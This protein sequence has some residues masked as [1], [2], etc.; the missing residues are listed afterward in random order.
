MLHAFTQRSLLLVLVAAWL[1]A[2][3]CSWLDT[4][5]PWMVGP[6]FVTAVLRMG[7]LPLSCPVQLREAGQW[8]I[9]AA[10]GL[11]FTPPVVAALGTYVGYIGAGV[12]YAIVLGAVCGWVLHRMT[13][14]DRTT[15]FFAMAV[16]GASEMAAQGERHG[17]RVDRVAAAHSLRILLVVALIPFGFKF[18]AVHGADPFE[19][20]VQAVYYPGLAL[21]IVLTSAGSLLLKRLDTPNAW[22][23]GPLL[24]SGALTATHHELSA[25]PGWIVHW[26]Q[27]F[28]GVSLGARFSPE[29]LRTAP[30]FLG[31]VVVCTLLAIGLGIGFALALAATGGMH[32]ATAILATAPGGVAEMSLTARNLNLGVPIVTAFHVTRMAALVLTIEPLFRH[33][34]AWRGRKKKE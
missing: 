21:L 8:A 23:I 2:L 30:R 12:V 9:G 22:V 13:G 16:G 3:F 34:R 19:P 20:G 5:L 14:I 11:Y 24:V 10:L 6:L 17:A 1:A 7:G 29:F 4:P 31:C 25:L 26:G 15:A 33:V 27:L 32:P 18:A 28:I